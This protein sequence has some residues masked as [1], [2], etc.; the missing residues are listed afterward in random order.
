M[1]SLSK[2]YRALGLGI[3]QVMFRMVTQEGVLRPV[4]GIQAV[5]AGAG[6]A[7][8]LYFSSYEYLKHSFTAQGFNSHLA[9]GNLNFEMIRNRMSPYSKYSCKNPSR[10][11]LFQGS[12]QSN[13]I[14]Y[15]YSQYYQ[16]TVG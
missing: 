9:S 5:V 16:R 8:A 4:R 1:Q 14:K 6:P 11:K 15:P 12:Y 7:H 13:C 10:L 2:D 3:R